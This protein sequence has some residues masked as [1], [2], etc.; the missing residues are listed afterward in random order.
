MDSVSLKT[1]DSKHPLF[2]AILRT[3]VCGDEPTVFQSGASGARNHRAP[4]LHQHS[5]AGAPTSSRQELDGGAATVAV[6]CPVPNDGECEFD[7]ALGPPPGSYQ[8][9]AA[10]AQAG[11]GDAGAASPPRKAAPRAGSEPR[12]LGSPPAQRKPVFL[13][14]TL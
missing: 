10:G 3:N 12:R 2:W 6:M 5:T 1:A 13:N 7:G 9:A 8:G 4:P 11:N 14:T